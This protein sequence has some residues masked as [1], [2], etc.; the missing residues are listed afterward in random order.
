MPLETINLSISR[1]DREGSNTHGGNNGNAASDGKGRA[2]QATPEELGAIR[3]KIKDPVFA[4]L[5]H[6]YM[7]SLSDPEVLREEEAYLEQ[8]EREAKEGGD[9]SFE[10]VF[11]HPGFVVELMNPMTKIISGS[12]MKKFLPM[13]AGAATTLK[14]IRSFV[15]MCSS[16]KVPVYREE[17]TGDRMG[18][19]WHVPVSI[20]QK[21]IEPF[22]GF[23]KGKEEADGKSRKG[24]NNKVA[25]SNNAWCYVYDAV[26][27]PQTLSLS[28]RSNRFL[29]FLVEIAVE[30]INSGYN[31]SNG[32]EFTRLS[33]SVATVVGTLKNQTIRTKDKKGASLFEVNRDA[34][35]L[36]KPTAQLLQTEKAETGRNS[37]VS[38]PT[39][40][41]SR[42]ERR[43]E[44]PAPTPH[45]NSPKVNVGMDRKP[46][47]PPHSILHRGHIDLTDAWS[48]KVVDKRIGVPEEL[49]VKL[50]F[51][52][53]QDASG[54]DISITE[55][56]SALRIDPTTAQNHYE[57]LVVL[58][59]TVEETPASA[60]FDRAT[61]VLT[62]I[63]RVVPPVL[64]EQSAAVAEEVK[65]RFRAVGGSNSPSAKADGGDPDGVGMSGDAQTG[66]VVVDEPCPVARE[67]RKPPAEDVD[68]PQDVRCAPEA[69]GI[70]SESASLDPSAADAGMGTERVE[71]PPCALPYD[72][73][74]VPS[75]DDASSE[76]ES[77]PTRSKPPSI[78]RAP[79]DEPTVFQEGK[80]DSFQHFNCSSRA[81]M[82]LSKI[83]EARRAREAAARPESE[84][85]P[86]QGQG[87]G[88]EREVSTVSEKEANNL[89]G[90]GSAP[91]ESEAA[92]LAS[93]QDAW[94]QKMNEQMA[95]VSAKEDEEA[96]AAALKVQRDAERSKKRLDKLMELEEMEK[97][98][99]Q[100]ARV[101]PLK[102][103]H[104]FSID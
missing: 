59:F 65:Q 82:A 53:V 56:G 97:R 79:V 91:D 36:T 7:E 86:T 32:F 22:N 87:F 1:P 99:L 8:A 71:S 4:K 74:N 46:L 35:V 101:I 24:E 38:A 104:I 54:L 9:F 6:E 70:A 37:Q 13:V 92:A 12:D 2:F 44:V 57:G 81:Q 21:R 60:R 10:F 50:T 84:A 72:H 80:D 52:R 16:E 78:F 85:G 63:L 41:S 75:K 89:L 76:V 67:A 98:M 62:L 20:S 34:P 88:E 100:K 102:N 25:D 40:T 83:M 58:P 23:N 28:D 15:N 95:A 55:D 48:W 49:V 73:V 3:E 103:R 96:E 45:V 43:G 51:D 26:F 31:E 42:A 27:H 93:E 94:V 19:N 77:M 11:P 90:V 68:N 30:H 64:S 61:H 14:D 33:S 69:T 47:L 17:P 39:S 5:M 66:D 18:S 29:C